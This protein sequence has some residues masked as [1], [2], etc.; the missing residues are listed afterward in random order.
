MK[1]NELNKPV[2]QEKQTPEQAGKSS[3]HQFA[4]RWQYSS[5]SGAQRLIYIANSVAV[6]LPVLWKPESSIHTLVSPPALYCSPTD[7]A[8]S[9]HSVANT[10]S[11]NMLN[12]VFALKK[13]FV[14]VSFYFDTCF[15]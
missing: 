3:F 13:R 15:I 4:T 1:D 10:H 8:Q 7:F 6:C 11:C 2:G 14:V 12:S 9:Q 5:L